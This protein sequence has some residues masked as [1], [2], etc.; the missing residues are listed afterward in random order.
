M[1]RGRCTT[2]GA[3]QQ[4]AHAFELVEKL[5]ESEDRGLREALR[6]HLLDR[7][8]PAGYLRLMG[9]RTLVLRERSG[10]PP[11]EAPPPAE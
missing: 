9:P 2:C 8:W 10:E 11:E 4:P 5:A 7:D 6:V 3:H 1:R